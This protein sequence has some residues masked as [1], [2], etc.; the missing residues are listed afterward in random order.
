MDLSIGIAVYASVVA[1]ATG[2]WAVYGVWRD[3]PSVKVEVR[4]DYITQINGGTLARSSLQLDTERIREDT[5]MI[6]MAMNAGRRPIVLRQRGIQ[7]DHIRLTFVGGGLDSGALSKTLPEGSSFD[8][9]TILSRLPAALKDHQPI[10]NLRAFWV[11]ETGKTYYGKVD[12]QLTRYLL[13]QQ[14]YP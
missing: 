14:G 7:V 1:T 9:W 8:T 11:T 12:N 2:V 6:V 4:I 10:S 3:R 5:R 13:G